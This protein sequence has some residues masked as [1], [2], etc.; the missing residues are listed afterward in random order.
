MAIDKTRTS[1]GMKVVIIVLIV[2]FA[3]L[4][5]AGAISQLSTGGSSNQQQTAQQTDAQKLQQITSQA[6]A[7]ISPNEAQLKTKPKDYTL[8]K[9]LGDEYSDYAGQVQQAEPNSGVDTAIWKQAVSYYQRALAVKRGDPNVMTD[10]AI[11][12]FYS[13]DTPAAI[14]TIE[15]VRKADPKFA[16]A[17]F[18]AGIFYGQSG[19]NAKAI[20]AFEEYLR[21]D[22][23]GPNVANANKFLAQLKATPATPGSVP[24]TKAP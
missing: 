20:A 8:L 18:N 5:A 7:G 17:V 24:A 16:P 10:M 4:G 6:Q 9:T 15:G 13:G 1:A 2:A 11:A 12:Q 23:K 3:M 21:I 14:V 22:P 19:Q